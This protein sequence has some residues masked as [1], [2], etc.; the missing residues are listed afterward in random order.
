L[1]QE[2]RK[3]KRKIIGTFA[4]AA[5]VACASTTLAGAPPYDNSMDTVTC[6]TILKG[7]VKPKPALT[8]AGGLGTTLIA[9]SGTLGG[10]SSPSNPALVFPEGKSKFKGVITSADNGC[11][12]L[13]GASTS[14]G[15]ITISWG[16]IPVLPATA[17][18]NKTS[19]VTLPSGSSVGGFGTFAGDAHGTFELGAPDGAALSVSG[20]FAGTDSGATSHAS[21][22]TTQSV[23]TIL[24]SCNAIAGLKSIAI[25]VGGIKV[26]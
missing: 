7:V 5:A 17:V 18:T 6:G 2:G 11:A 20:G 4:V 26:Q 10:C 9:I 15:T 25:G 24:N 23:T 22:I 1:G 8:T 14:T 19:I 13:N 12:G 16:V 3:V 21:I